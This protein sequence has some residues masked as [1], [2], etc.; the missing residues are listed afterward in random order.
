[1][2]LLELEGEPVAPIKASNNPLRNID[3]FIYFSLSLPSLSV[4]TSP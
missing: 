3:T 1:M 4:P 2:E